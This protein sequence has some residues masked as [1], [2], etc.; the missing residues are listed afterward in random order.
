MYGAQAFM[1]K[2]KATSGIVLPWEKPE[3]LSVPMSGLASVTRDGSAAK[4]A[5]PSS[6]A[7]RAGV[8]MRSGRLKGL[9]NIFTA[10]SL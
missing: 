1:G 6:K 5:V 3:V 8:E 9:M 4:A 10:R 7:I 2:G